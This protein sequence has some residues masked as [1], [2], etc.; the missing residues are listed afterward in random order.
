MNKR[1]VAALFFAAMGGTILIFTGYYGTS[2][3]FWGLAI[4][5]LISISPNQL[6]TDILIIVLSFLSFIS[7][8]GGWT[9]L[10]GCLF[11]LLGRHR[12]AF[13]FIIIGAGMSLMGLIW[14]LVQMWI[15]G[16][17]NLATFLSQ[18]QGLAWL[19]AIFAII[20]QELIRFG[21]DKPE[22]NPL[23][24]PLDEHVQQERPDEPTSSDMEMDKGD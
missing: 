3:G 10:I 18:Y 2:T 11:I 9:V 19:G 15:L 24:E 20:G 12:T 17:L 23:E 13:Y 6:I 21:K 8:M 16:T 7:F 4:Q 1:N 5:I 14:N 22:E